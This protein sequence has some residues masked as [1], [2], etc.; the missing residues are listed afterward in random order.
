MKAHLLSAIIFWS[1]AS[2]YAG[3]NWPAFR[4]NHQGHAPEST[5]VPLS[6]STEEN[7]RWKVPVAG[8]AWS[9]P[10]AVG[11]RCYVTTAVELDSEAKEISL[12]ALALNLADGSTI[13]DTEVFRMPS[14]RIHKKNSHASPTPVYEDGR[15]Y[16]HFG[17]QGTACLSAEDGKIDWTQNSLSYAPVH[18]NG[19]SPIIAGDKLIYSADGNK[20]PKLIALNK[21]DGTV[22]W[23]K[24]RDVE[25]RRFFSFS[26][27]L[28]IDVK[29]KPQVISACSGAVISYH[30]ETGKE[31]WRCLYGE[32]YSVT[33]RPVFANGLIYASSGFDRAI[34][35][36]IRP[37]GKG[38]VTDTHVEWTYS[39]TVPR[40]SSFIVVDDLFY[41][42]DDKGIVTC[43]DAKTGE[44]HYAERI[45]PEGGYSG[46]PVYASGHL[47][48]NN[49]EGVTTVVKPGKTFNKAGENRL[50]EYGLSTFAVLEDGF[51]HRTESH[52]VRIGK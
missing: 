13:W 26:T 52:L 20:D 23:E 21:N 11:D 40:E 27:P 39:K 31:I 12:R 5:S 48:F 8:K 32:G 42:N 47:F 33:P 49:G 2:I 29:G 43:L 17:H 24:A 14:G 30:P 9:S 28:L 15:I 44:L 38:D 45:S 4:G 7:I 34:A 51:L 22:A 25:V 18:G 41:M 6:W 37:D 3:E 35:Y 16:V 46:S 10:I 1:T 36:A 19:S 50:G